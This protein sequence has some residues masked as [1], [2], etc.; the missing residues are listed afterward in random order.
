MEQI[1]LG[2]ENNLDVSVY[3]NPEFDWKKMM[4]FRLELKESYPLLM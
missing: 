2:L 1:R 3:S 4:K